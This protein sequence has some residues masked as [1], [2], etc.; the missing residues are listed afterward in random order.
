MIGA[1][2][3][4]LPAPEISTKVLPRSRANMPIARVQSG[5]V[6]FKLVLLLWDPGHAVWG[7]LEA[8][9]RHYYHIAGV[10]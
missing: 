2:W 9:D 4:W 1:G 10:R 6:S 5:D 8:L 7:L 3:W